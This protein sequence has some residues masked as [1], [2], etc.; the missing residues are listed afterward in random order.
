MDIIIDEWDL[1]SEQAKF[2]KTLSQLFTEKIKGIF[3]DIVRDNCNG[4]RIDHPS[5]RQHICIMLDVDDLIRELFVTL[6]DYVDWEELNRNCC[7][8]IDE[9]FTSNK[10]ISKQVLL[11][12]Y[13]WWNYTE[14]ALIKSLNT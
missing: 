4:C 10:I 8:L 2:R 7:K 13:E 3:W 12:D 6:L 1:N 11:D 5:Q 9:K 14:A